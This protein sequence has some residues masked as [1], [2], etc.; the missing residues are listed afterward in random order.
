MS[1]PRRHVPVMLAEV[2]AAIAPRDGALYVDGTFGQGGYSRAFLDAADCTVWGIDRDPASVPAGNELRSRYGDRF[3]L[4]LGRFGRMDALLAARG[5]DRVDGVALDVGVSS[6]QL[7]DAVR[8]FS[9]LKDGP[10]DMRMSGTGR[11][12][13]DLV[14]GEPEDTLADLIYMLGEERGARR[15]AR[16]IAAA[17]ARKPITRT[18]ELAG[19]VRAVVGSGRGRTAID[20]VTRTFQA[21]RICINDELGELT[22]GLEAAEA[23]LR[24][25]GRLAAVTFHSLEDRRVKNFLFERAGGRPRPSRHRPDRS[26]SG[27]PATFRLLHRRPRRPS[28][29][30]C[31]ANPRARS[32]RLRAAERMSA[33]GGT[34]S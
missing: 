15:I 12:A 7:D 11:T 26:E 28:R 20:P 30:E 1:A 23:L 24:P 31:A 14:N 2:L 3:A 34:G 8:G 18:G 22:R 29:S 27:R 4:V 17:R 32:A 19:V 6:I 13:A 33:P 10:L 16:A 21:I 25:G 9:F 5:I